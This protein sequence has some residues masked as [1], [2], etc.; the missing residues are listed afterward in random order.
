[1]PEIAWL[2][3]ARACLPHSAHLSIISFRERG[4]C[5]VCVREVRER[6]AESRKERKERKGEERKETREG[7]EMKRERRIRNSERR[8]STERGERE[9]GE[10]VCVNLS[11][12]GSAADEDVRVQSALHLIQPSLD[13]LLV[14]CASQ[15]RQKNVSG[16][17]TKRASC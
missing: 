9:R 17:Q 7:S 5:R 1:M 10:R 3:P 16:Q 15:E 8:A 11:S 14:T 6:R 12:E 4:L 2:H 13:R